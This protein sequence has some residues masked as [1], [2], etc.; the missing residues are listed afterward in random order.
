MV[1]KSKTGTTFE[2]TRLACTRASSMSCDT[3]SFWWAS[4][5]LSRL[6]TNERENPSGPKATARYITDMPP[7]AIFL[8]SR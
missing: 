1:P 4:S 3:A 5:G 8:T 7:S 6:T 2:W